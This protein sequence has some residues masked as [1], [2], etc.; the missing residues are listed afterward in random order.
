MSIKNRLSICLL[1]SFLF[2]SGSVFSGDIPAVTPNAQRPISD[3]LNPAGYLDLKDKTSG[4]FDASGF[5]MVTGPGGEPRFLPCQGHAES[6]RSGGEWDWDG[7]FWVAG[8]D[9]YVRSL[10]VI[11]ADLYV[12]GSFITITTGSG[13]SIKANYI[14]KWDGTQWSALG[15]GMDASVVSLAVIGSVL[16]AGGY[17]TTSGGIETNCIAKWDGTQWST[18]GSGMDEP[19]HYAW[20]RSLAVIGSELYAGGYFTTSGDIEA[21]CVAKWDGT[22]WSALGTGTD[23]GVIALAVD[24]MDLYAGGF[25]TSAGGIGANHIAKWDGS[26]WSAL[27]SGMDDSVASLAVIGSDLFAGGDFTTAGSVTANC[28]AKWDGTQWSALGT[29]MDNLVI[30][31]ASVGTD[32][33]AGGYFTTAGGAP[34]NRMAKWDGTQWSTLGAGMGGFADHVDSLTVIGTDLYA[35]GHFAFADSVSANHIAKWDGTQ[36]SALETDAG[37]G[38]NDTILAL[39]VIG[40]DLY[41]GGYFTSAGGV[42]ANHIA[43]WDGAQWSALGTGT[44]GT[45]HALAAIGTDLYAGGFFTSAGGASANYIAK[46]D[47]THWSALGT[48]TDNI[49]SALAVM[50]TDLY[51]GGHFTTAGD[52]EA[53]FVAK[54]DGTQWSSLGTGTNNHVTSL[55]V[56]GTD[57][58]AGGIFSI[59]GGTTANGI[60]Q[61]NGTEWF[62]LGAGMGGPYPFVN[63]LAAIGLDLY[64][65]GD[66]TTAGDVFANRVAKWDGVQWS[67]LGVGM[68]GGVA[69]LAVFGTALYAGGGFTRAGGILA[70]RSAKWDGTQWSALGVGT[71]GAP[72]SLAIVGADLYAGGGFSTAGGKQSSNIARWYRTAGALLVPVY[73]FFNTLR[74]GHLYTISQVERDYIINNLP[75][76]NYEGAK[77]KVYDYYAPGTRAAYRFFN[78]RTGIHFY[79]ISEAERDAVMQLPHFNYEGIKFFVHQNTHAA[80]IPVFRFFNSARGWHLYTISAHERDA[81]LQLPQW[82]YEGIPFYVYP[83]HA[84]STAYS[85]TH[86]MR[87]HAKGALPAKNH[88]SKPSAGDKGSF[89]IDIALS[90]LGTGTY[91]WSLVMDTSNTIIGDNSWRKLS[92]YT[93]QKAYAGDITGDASLELVASFA[94]KGLWYYQRDDN[95]WSQI[96]SDFADCI[97]FALAEIKPAMHHRIIA[98]CSAGVYAGNSAGKWTKLS[99]RTAARITVMNQNGRDKVFFVFEDGLYT[100]DFARDQFCKLAANVPSAILP[101]DITGNGNEELVCIAGNALIIIRYDESNACMHHALDIKTDSILSD[102]TDFAFIGNGNIA[103]TGGHELFFNVDGSTM[104]FSYESASWHSFLDIGVER[105]I[106]LNPAKGGYDGLIVEYDGKLYFSSPGTNTLDF[107]AESAILKAVTVYR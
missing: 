35:G 70:N 51:A 9:L 14:A 33:Y 98:S 71:N 20:V 81:L 40:T 26:Q 21:N 57:L 67:A 27:G 58:Y 52:S 88:D 100:Y 82:N 61:W 59:A 83:L 43:K 55:A 79:T 7:R 95:Q 54:W 99:Q 44:G 60:A 76:W 36:W 56:I 46:W 13:S 65:G 34:A 75:Q 41:A 53:K 101:L 102:R 23:G 37:K 22:Q 12:G 42:S 64:A 24:D 45:V 32:L 28:I 10:A 92:D 106:P 97:D 3:I 1:L 25:F 96:K 47:G 74:G 103:G 48:G 80:T 105:I 68:N 94:G 104:Y 6:G 8:P 30:S 2:A 84:P 77:F 38:M 4:S 89:P 87:Y 5:R 73:R 66:F 78:T 90:M 86:E 16:Y 15:S 93:A 39:A 11:G 91:T 29:G 18:L 107:L 31:L 49:V 72:G 69:A 50:G 17:F 62:C 19:H 63:A 85:V